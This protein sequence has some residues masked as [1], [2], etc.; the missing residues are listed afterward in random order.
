MPSSFLSKFVKS[1][2]NSATSNTS[3]GTSKLF[4]PSP[5]SPSP[6][7]PA[8]RS[9]SRSQSS[10]TSPVL[11]DSPKESVFDNADTPT[12]AR[13]SD[14]A[15][16]LP[17]SPSHT[18]SATF[19]GASDSTPST[20]SKFKMDSPRHKRTVSLSAGTEDQPG[21]S[22][23][24]STPPQ[25]YSVIVDSPHTLR[26]QVAIQNQNRIPDFEPDRRSL[27]SSGSRSNS[28]RSWTKRSTT[29]V[30][31]KQSSSNKRVPSAGG[32]AGALAASGLAMANAAGGPVQQLTTP[33]LVPPPVVRKRTASRTSAQSR[34]R[35]SPSRPVS[36]ELRN[37]NSPYQ[38]SQ[39][40][41]GSQIIASGDESETDD[42]TGYDSPDL[43]LNVDDI[44]VTGFA[45]ASN[46]RNADFHELFPSVPEG[47]YLIEGDLFRSIII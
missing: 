5:P 47:D 26:E 22:M 15:L 33:Q 1:P 25:Q 31:R 6:S 4:D 41:T 39:P 17:A 45:V 23:E 36:S 40:S 43:D 19:N 21:I 44:P 32:I 2:A 9:H 11:A 28:K 7:R 3:T 16:A 38:T 42:D 24:P 35:S 29:S 37:P 13:H 46:K 30:S 8:S 27:H 12:I 34:R 20:S 18:R 14:K 10:A